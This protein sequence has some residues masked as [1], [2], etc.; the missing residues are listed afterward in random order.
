MTLRTR[1]KAL[2]V[3]VAIALCCGPCYGLAQAPDVSI[4]QLG[5]L[6]GRA[7]KP[8]DLTSSPRLVIV[9]HGDLASPQKPYQYRFAA[10]VQRAL[11]D[12]VVLAL[13]RPGYADAYGAR[14]EGQRGWAIGDN[15]TAKDVEALRAATI[16]AKQQFSPRDVTLVGHSGGAA[17]AAL[18]AERDPGLVSRLL[19]VSCPC[20]LGKWRRHMAVSNLNPAWFLPVRSLSPINGVQG[21]SHELRL[22]MLVGARDQTTPPEL[23]LEFADAARTAGV[24]TTHIV[25]EGMGHEILLDSRIVTELAALQA[26]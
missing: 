20:N 22:K 4:M 14:S 9:I 10:A 3:A 18:L 12:T 23:T 11:A 24:K 8:P 26:E 1:M 5:E 2:A 15:Y 13:L 7:W 6:Q 25:F 21:L 19:L 16:A 17:L